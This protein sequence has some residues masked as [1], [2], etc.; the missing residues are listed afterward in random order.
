M[1]LSI[2]YQTHLTFYAKNLRLN[3]LGSTDPKFRLILCSKYQNLTYALRQLSSEFTGAVS[4]T[5]RTHCSLLK[6]CYIL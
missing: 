6:R 4:G 3:H 2:Q 1:L 5:L